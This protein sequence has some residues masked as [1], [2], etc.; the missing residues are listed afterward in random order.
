MY[1]PRLPKKLLGHVTGQLERVLAH[2][3]RLRAARTTNVVF[4]CITEPTGKYLDQSARL[5]LSLRW[6]GGDLA[7]S[8]FVLGTTGTLPDDAA[9]FFDR[10]GGEVAVVERFD[11]SHGES[12]KISL[13]GSS[14]LEGHDV[15][16]LLD[17]DTVIVRDPS[18]WLS[19]RGIAAKPADVATVKHEQLT[20]VFEAL[21]VPVPEPIYTHDVGGQPCGPYCNSGVV[22]VREKYRKDLATAWARFNRRT[23]RGIEGAPFPPR[24]SDQ[25]SLA[26]AIVAT[27]IPYDPLPTA[28]N[29]PAHLVAER[30]PPSFQRIDPAIVHYHHLASPDG[31][32]ERTS[33]AQTNRRIEAFNA[34][35][36]AE[37]HGARPLIEAPSPPARPGTGQPKVIVG[38]GWWCAEK[39]HEW[40]LGSER[41]RTITFFD[42]WWRQVMRCIRPTRIIVTDSAAPKKPD[43]RRYPNVEWV[44][45]DQNYGQPNHIRTGKIQ[46]KYSGFTRSVLNGA[47]Y[48]LSCDADWYVYVEQDCLVHGEDLIRHAVGDSDGDIL[49]GAPTEGGRGIGGKTAARFLQQSLMIVRRPGL[50]RFVT[51]LLNAPWTDGEMSPE[52]IM[53]RQLQP[54]DTLRIPYGRSRPIDFS[55]SH[56]YAQHCDDEEL[57]RFLEVIGGSLPE[58]GFAF[59]DLAEP[60]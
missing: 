50:E 60:H 56:F 4:T 34:R 2:A 11:P 18:R 47:M 10:F 35:L 51:G 45:L 30:Y 43:W 9:R 59:A 29:L 55:R 44:E 19:P 17:C 31:M 15:V 38:S 36:R 23:L 49:L 37:R 53:Q 41:N 40:A 25:L 20:R 39:S 21:G 54:F 7:R 52:H 46:T 12:N 8:R 1:Q 14:V 22:V 57:D 6:F 42:I 3:S 28:L 32:L 26:L 33:L 16:A 27:G 58:P 5:L 24:Y 13:I 48:A